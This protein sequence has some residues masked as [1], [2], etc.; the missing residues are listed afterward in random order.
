[1]KTVPSPSANGVG[2]ASSITTPVPEDLAEAKVRYDEELSCILPAFDDEEDKDAA[3]ELNELVEILYSHSSL[4]CRRGAVI[5]LICHAIKTIE[6]GSSSRVP[7]LVEKDGG[8]SQFDSAN[9]IT[10]DYLQGGIFQALAGLTETNQKK[11]T[12]YAERLKEISSNP[13]L[14]PTVCQS[15]D[16]LRQPCLGDG[17]ISFGKMKA[18]LSSR[19]CAHCAQAV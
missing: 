11:A 12:A 1:M 13:E 7:K 9:D 5:F 6:N 10:S 18:K 15:D 2:P 19:L 14:D 3:N 17:N 16:V 8:R 4:L